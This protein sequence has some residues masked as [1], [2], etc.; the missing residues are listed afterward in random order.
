M[1][2]LLVQLREHPPSLNLGGFALHVQAIGVFGPGCRLGVVLA[3]YAEGS[4][5]GPEDFLN[6][7]LLAPPHREA[8]YAIVDHYGLLICK[9]VR[10]AHPSY[11]G[12]RGRS[13]RGR[14]SQGEYYHHDGCSAPSKPRV[15]EIRFPYQEVEREVATAIAAFPDTVYAMLRHVGEVLKPDAELRAWQR[16]L[17]GEQAL[18]DADLNLVQGMVLRAVRRDLSA[19]G[20]R[21]YLRRVDELALAYRQ[22]WEMGESRLIANNPPARGQLHT[23]QHRRAYL[24]PHT[25]G[26]ANGSL[27]KRWPAEELRES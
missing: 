23:M 6:E 12:V 11:R 16:R 10:S 18:S 19:E 2:E 9:Q 15:V 21:A 8:S 14:L 1:S 3:G 25:P 13:S 26:V 17:E 7:L 4:P 24:R 27:V 5:A 20:A 22:P